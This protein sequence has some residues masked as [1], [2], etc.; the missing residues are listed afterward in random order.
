MIIVAG[1]V[2]IAAE[3]LDAARPAM[4]RVIAATR[5]EDGC[6]AYAY[7]QDLLDPGLIH[8]AERWRDRDA[9]R[10]HFAAAHMVEW[11]AAQP[12]L[13]LFDKSLRI[14]ETDEGEPI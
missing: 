2:R 9:L 3:R 4:A 12:G 5:A 8:V 1:T 10:A 6:L 7:A 11:R 14:Y 13:G